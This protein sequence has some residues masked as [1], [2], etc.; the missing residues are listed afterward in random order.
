[1]KSCPGNGECF[2]PNANIKYHNPKND[3]VTCDHQCTIQICPNYKLCNRSAPK[4]LFDAH[5]GR[6]WTCNLT[7]GIDL[8]FS[9]QRIECPICFV[10][11][12]TSVAFPGCMKQH[13]ICTK[14]FWNHHITGYQDETYPEEERDWEEDEAEVNEEDE[15]DEARPHP[16]QDRQD[17]CMICRSYWDASQQWIKNT[18]L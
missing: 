13:F 14:C 7:F 9:D 3:D 1:M 12:E 8:T 16:N 15:G 17:K 11:T 2:K 5:H 4:W 18:L 6:C 10:Q